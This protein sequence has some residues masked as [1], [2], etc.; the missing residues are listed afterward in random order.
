MLK[1]R[2]IVKKE[3]TMSDQTQSQQQQPLQTEEEAKQ[4]L[5]TLEAKKVELH[6]QSVLLNF[7][8]QVHKQG[9]T[10]PTSTWFQVGGAGQSTPPVVRV[11]DQAKVMAP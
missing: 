5:I 10:R 2:F 1:N 3:R 4:Q 7:Y 9:V 8:I 11:S 6:N